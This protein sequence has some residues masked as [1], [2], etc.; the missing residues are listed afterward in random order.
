MKNNQNKKKKF[1]LHLWL[2][3]WSF[4]AVKN[5]IL[6]SKQKYLLWILILIAVGA[7]GVSIYFYNSYR[8]ANQSPQ[9]KIKAETDKLLTQV[10]KIV[11]LPG[12]ETPTIATISDPDKLKNQPFFSDAQEGDKV[13]IYTNAKKAFIYRPSIGKIISVAPLMID[14]LPELNTPA[15]VPGPTE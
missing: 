5:K 12:G 11:L 7:S 10:S 9:E 1:N 6:E 14:A 4:E 2:K 8:Q 13:L 15:P 3:T